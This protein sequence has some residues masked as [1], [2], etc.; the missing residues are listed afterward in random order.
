MY[1]SVVI[2]AYNEEKRIIT[3]LLD[4]DKYL[5][6]QNYPSTGPE[7]IDYEVIVISDGSTDNTV[8]AIKNLKEKVKNLRVI[9]NKK[10]YGKGYVVRQGMLE[11]KGKYRLFMDADNSTTIDHLDK[12]WEYAKEN[13]DIVI[14]SIGIK[15]AKI[16]ENAAFY[17]RWLG[18]IS[19][20]IIRFFSGLW[21]IHDTQ[22][23][24]KL[25]NKN[26]AEKIFSKQTIQRFGFDIEILVLAKKMGYK[27][28]EVP[29]NWKNPGASKV[30]LSDY[31]RT[32]KELLKIKYNLLTNK[33][34]IKNND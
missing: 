3:T 30:S 29:V 28:K 15:G 20:Y 6:N 14:A 25:F 33:Y 5:S 22:R 13:Y 12:F 18:K 24:F 10:N 26:A 9:D 16:Q 11:A 2:P 19:K 1:L 34:K 21:N 23:G 31:I 17:R 4:I 8:K 7:E 27:I 32:F